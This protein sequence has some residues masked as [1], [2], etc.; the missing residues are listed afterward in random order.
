[1][2]RFDSDESVDPRM[3]RALRENDPLDS[4]MKTIWMMEEQLKWIVEKMNKLEKKVDDLV[5]FKWKMIGAI[6]LGSSV[7]GVAL[8]RFLKLLEGK[9]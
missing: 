7:G 3:S 5:A 1:M 4:E 8:A 6:S 2:K 9:I